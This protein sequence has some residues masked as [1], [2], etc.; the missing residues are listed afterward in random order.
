[1]KVKVGPQLNEP[2]RAARA[3]PL[4]PQKTRDRE[5]K[6]AVHFP[7]KQYAEA[8]LVPYGQIV[9]QRNVVP[10]GCER[11]ATEKEMLQPDV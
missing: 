8:N 6:E 9:R 10:G 1:M 11:R 7:K 3:R 2:P 5:M 4:S